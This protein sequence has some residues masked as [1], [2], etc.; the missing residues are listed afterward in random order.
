MA[1]V[2]PTFIPGLSVLGAFLLAYT[3]PQEAAAAEAAE[4]WAQAKGL[5]RVKSMRRNDNLPVWRRPDS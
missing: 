4:A 3:T 5:L 2:T 1:A